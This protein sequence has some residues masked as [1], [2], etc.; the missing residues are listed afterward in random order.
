MSRDSDALRA[1]FEPIARELAGLRRDLHAHPEVAFE[2]A[3]TA[4][5]VAR[6]LREAGI[7]VHEAIGRTGV[8]GVLRR[9]KAAAANGGLSCIALR[10][11]MDALPVP[12]ANTFAH[13]S[14]HDG[15]MH[16]CGHD[17]HTAML[18]GAARWLQAYGEFSG[19][20]CFVFQPAEESQG[21]A[22]AML[23]DGL[24]Q[25][26]PIERFY[27]MHNWPGM[28]AGHF[29][30]IDGP[31]MAAADEFE[32]VIQGKGAHGAMPQFGADP[33]V[34]GAA[35]VQALQT[36]VTRTLDPLDPV[37]LSVT[38]FH[39]GHANN[40]IPAQA[41]LGGT[42]RTF[43]AAVQGSLEAAMLR[44]CEGIATAYGVTATLR[45]SRGYPATRNDPQEA[46]RC[47]AAAQAI[48][49]P[50][51]EAA[52]PSMGAEDFSMFA[53]ERP[54]CYVWIGNGPGEG[55][56]TLH[57]PYYDFND[58]LIETGV[59]YWSTLVESALPAS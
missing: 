7:E 45:Y 1:S 44:V 17:G 52:R 39:A 11:D 8:V 57:S 35:L 30:I 29:A 51:V 5:V 31:V 59:R 13:R 26:F 21:G 47:R 54:A 20:V 40:V 48:G 41:I 53:Q 37:V 50:L 28:P 6:V 23:A 38:R 58:S 18:L 46:A 42:A 56:C 16:A 32:I 55:G 3:R 15:K 33:V 10:A 22:A 43:R 25:R 36:I 4:A 27:G 24:L 14:R 49:A 19:T 2:E 34:A 9:G 12:E